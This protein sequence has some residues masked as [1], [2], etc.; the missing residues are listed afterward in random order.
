MCVVGND[1]K[2][3]VGG[4]LLHDAA[5]GHLCGGSHG[6]GFVKDY[7]F[8]VTERLKVS[9]FRR[10]RKDLFGALKGSNQSEMQSNGRALIVIISTGGRRTCKCLN[11][12]SHHVNS[13]V[14]ASIEFQNHLPHVFIAVD[15]P[16]Q[17]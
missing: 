7:E 11:L 10:G 13:S 4:I 2:A 9:R 5:E 14:I 16:C 3:G 15:S 6:I 8:V 12:F 17:S 1:A